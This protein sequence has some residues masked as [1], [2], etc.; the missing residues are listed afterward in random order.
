MPPRLSQRQVI[1]LTGG[2]G[3]YGVT[4]Y[5][6]YHAYR[7]HM[8]PQPP[9]SISDPK[10]QPPHPGVFDALAPE[11]DTRIGWDEWLMR[12]GTRRK[13][14]VERAK[15]DV[16]EV[17]AGTGRNIEYYGQ[18]TAIKT[19]TLS[20][21]SEPMLHKAWVRYTS[22]ANAKHRLPEASFKIMDVQKLP[23]PDHKFD[24]VIDTFGLC[25]CS[26]PVKALNE[27]GRTC[28]PDGKILL[29]QHGRGYLAW[30][31]DALDKTANDHAEKWGCWW[32][33]DIDSMVEAAGL[34][35]VESRR[36]HFGTTVW[37]VA[38]PKKD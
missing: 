26:D 7:I 6:S 28:K 18:N 25:S 33:R 20:D 9:A 14:L 32:N 3:L 17:S 16:L 1:L 35:I 27:M 23:I 30:L 5:L 24:T 10:H 19:I 31:N 15:G 21:V 8:A 34:E 2:L 36:Y 4:S 37:I 11:Y 38:K 22:Y 29:L 13:Q 12:L